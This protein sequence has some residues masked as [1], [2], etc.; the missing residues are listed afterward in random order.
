VIAVQQRFWPILFGAVL[1]AAFLLYV[2]AAFVPGWWLPRDVSTYG[3]RIDWLFYLIL[4]LTGF[5]FVLTEALLVYNMWR[6]TARPG[7]KAAYV[8]GNH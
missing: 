1:A 2:V 5:F 3:W 8:H 6:F 7:E 4:F